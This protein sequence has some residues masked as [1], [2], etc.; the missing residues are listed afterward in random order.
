MRSFD[1][2]GRE[3]TFGAAAASL[4]DSQPGR[5]CDRGFGRTSTSAQPRCRFARVAQPTSARPETPAARPLRAR[6]GA[7]G[8]Q[9]LPRRNDIAPSRQP[10]GAMYIVRSGQLLASRTAGDGE[11]VTVQLTLREAVV[12]DEGAARSR[13]A[14]SD[15]CGPRSAEPRGRSRRVPVAAPAPGRTLATSGRRARHDLCGW[16]ADPLLSVSCAASSSD[17]QGRAAATAG[18]ARRPDP[19]AEEA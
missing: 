2:D 5:H 8:G 19:A 11:E 4:V 9:P 18:R 7:A 15:S 12:G 16:R 17:G 14:A 6:A 3:R 10:P 1:H 13:C